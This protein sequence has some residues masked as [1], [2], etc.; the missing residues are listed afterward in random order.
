MAPVCH[1]DGD[2]GIGQRRFFA[3]PYRRRGGNPASS[4]TLSVGRR[5]RRSSGASRPG[6]C[7]AS[8]RR[9]GLAALVE[10]R[11]LPLA[12]AIAGRCDVHLTAWHHEAVAFAAHHSP[13]ALRSA[14]RE[15]QTTLTRFPTVSR[16]ISDKMIARLPSNFLEIRED[17]PFEQSSN[18][19]QQ[20]LLLRKQ[21]PFRSLETRAFE[22]PGHSRT[23]LK[24]CFS[25]SERTLNFK[26]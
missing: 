23:R 18:S 26:G 13:A 11:I 14:F 12:E 7:S 2:E 6:A 16:S 3:A 5:A 24:I 22:M 8:I 15:I 21:A 25:S 19:F 10:R 9:P 1:A 20:W 4:G 17:R